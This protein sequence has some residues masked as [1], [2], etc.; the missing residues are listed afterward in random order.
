MP[1]HIL[2]LSIFFCLHHTVGVPLTSLPG[3][4]EH[5]PFI[6]DLTIAQMSGILN[7][8]STIVPYIFIDPAAP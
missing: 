3:A 6:T 1:E 4:P 2:I 7:G 5:V 8:F